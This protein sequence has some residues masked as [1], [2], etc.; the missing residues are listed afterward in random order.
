MRLQEEPQLCLLQ[1]ALLRKLDGEKIM[2][3]LS[4]YHT[5]ICIQHNIYTCQN[6]KREALIISGYLGFHTSA[7]VS[8]PLKPS[9]A[10]H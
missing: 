7:W 2:E 4:K 8:P 3:D 1:M 6:L 9:Q 10:G 5:I